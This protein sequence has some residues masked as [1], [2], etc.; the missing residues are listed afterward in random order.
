MGPLINGVGVL[1]TG[2]TEKVEILNAF[3]A[4]VFHAKT[5]PQEFLILEVIERV[6]GKK[7]FPFTE[8][9]LIREYQAKI[10]AHKSDPNGMHSHVLKWQM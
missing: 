6:W 2:D 10:S 8:K 4:S 3:F 5:S 7:G 9:N 1:E